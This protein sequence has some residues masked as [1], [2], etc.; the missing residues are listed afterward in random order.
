ME[1]LLDVTGMTCGNCV[2]HVQK[3][4]EQVDGVSSVKVE[5]ESGTARVEHDGRA[6]LAS[7]V[8]AVEEEG[9]GAR[10]QP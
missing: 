4:L 8:A 1:T 7:L 9:Y 6:A 3:A 5:L 2:R 10:A